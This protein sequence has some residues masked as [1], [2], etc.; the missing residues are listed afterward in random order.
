MNRILSLARVLSVAVVLVSACTNG[1][2]RIE[3]PVQGRVLEFRGS[4]G[5][6]MQH[7][8]I[9]GVMEAM[10]SMAFTARDST[11]LQAVSVGDSVHFVWVFEGQFNWIEDVER[12]SE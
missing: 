3:H 10:A 1:P 4:N 8:D 9:P 2:Q 11:E 12:I 5:V 6:L 7:G